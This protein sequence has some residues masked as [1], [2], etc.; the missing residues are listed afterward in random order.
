[1]DGARAGPAAGGAGGGAALAATT[2]A[3]VCQ[4][5]ELPP[6]GVR[7]APACPG[8][9]G[10]PFSVHL[11]SVGALARACRDGRRPSGDLA[12]MSRAAVPRGCDHLRVQVSRA[13]LLCFACCFS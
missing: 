13:S 4:A 11:G 1:L 10:A 2:I 8:V 5:T 3:Y 6:K 7:P 12:A 9:L